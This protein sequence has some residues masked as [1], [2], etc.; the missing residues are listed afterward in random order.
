MNGA[1]LSASGKRIWVDTS[2]RW[3]ERGRGGGR[4]AARTRPAPPAGRGASTPTPTIPRRPAPGAWRVRACPACPPHPAPPRPPPARRTRYSPPRSRQAAGDVTELQGAVGGSGCTPAPG[5]RVPLGDGAP[6][7]PPLPLHRP[8]S[9]ARRPRV[10]RAWR[11]S[12]ASRARPPEFRGSRDCLLPVRGPTGPSPDP[13]R[14]LR[15]LPPTLPRDCSQPCP[16][17]PARLPGFPSNASPRRAALSP[18]LSPGD[19]PSLGASFTLPL[20]A[21][22]PGLLLLPFAGSPP[23]SPRILSSQDGSGLPSSR[24]SPPANTHPWALHTG[25][26]P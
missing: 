6:E 22:Y 11:S 16:S 5:E 2:E 18:A 24:L 9:S 7:M 26:V 19:P 10:P 14:A 15:S 4:G 23:P 13:L 17:L 25:L 1:I 8:P 21:I 12:P 20:A 3:G